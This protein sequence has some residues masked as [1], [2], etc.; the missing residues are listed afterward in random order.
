MLPPWPDPVLEAN[1]AVVDRRG[2]VLLPQGN[3]IKILEIPHF[4]LDPFWM[5]VGLDFQF[6]LGLG[7]FGIVVAQER[8]VGDGIA[9][10]A[11]NFAMPAG[12]DDPAILTLVLARTFVDAHQSSPPSCA[13]A[14]AIRSL[15]WASVL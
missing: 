8:L 15:I 9:V 12:L 6:Q 13:F 4:R 5:R 14:K 3:E 11:G 10:K 1:L 7:P 2:L